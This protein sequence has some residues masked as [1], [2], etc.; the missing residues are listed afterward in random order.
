MLNRNHTYLRIV[1][2]AGL[3]L[4][5]AIARGADALMEFLKRRNAETFDLN[6]V[7][8]GSYTLIGL[9][10]AALTLL[11]FWFMLN[12]AP[13]NVWIALLYVLAGT[14]VVIYPDLSFTPALCCWFPPFD[15]FIV[16][17]TSYL[18]FSGAFIAI[19]G[20]YMLILPRATHTDS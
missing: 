13:R 3:V 14:F 4:L 16:L 20:L 1:S 15:P 8:F 17:P 9:A 5:L 19:I 11:L 6:S 18:S 10:F 7:V 2:I 12:R